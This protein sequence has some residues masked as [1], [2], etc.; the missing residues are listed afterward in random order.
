[1]SARDS[2]GGFWAGALVG[3][4]LGGVAAYV[5]APQISKFLLGEDGEAD[6]I[7]GV[8]E[9]NTKLTGEIAA[10]NRC[11]RK[12]GPLPRASIGPDT[13]TT[14]RDADSTPTPPASPALPA[15][16]GALLRGSARAQGDRHR[17]GADGHQ[18]GGREDH[19]ERHG[20]HARP[21]ID[22]SGSRAGAGSARA[23]ARGARA[24]PER[25]RRFRARAAL[26]S[27][28]LRAWT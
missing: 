6:D 2:G 5:F 19:Q 27:L 11:A 9:T 16:P 14:T 17:E 4:V 25:R 22:L 12:R 15:P 10:L 3:G 13:P 21:G 7:G 28:T 23:S 8:E 24:R 26:S 20:R 1:M 18:D